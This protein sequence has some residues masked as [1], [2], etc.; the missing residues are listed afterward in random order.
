[1]GV[2]RKRVV[3]RVK[4]LPT[5][6]VGGG[7]ELLPSNKEGF[8]FRL[9]LRVNECK[10]AVPG[11]SYRIA[12][13]EISFGLD[14]QNCV[15]P[16]EDWELDPPIELQIETEEVL[17]VSNAVLDGDDNGSNA[18]AGLSI[19]TL[20]KPV[21]LSASLAVDQKITHSESRRVSQKTTQKSVSRMI[22]SAGNELEPKWFLKAKNSAEHLAGAIWKS[23]H[24]LRLVPTD[25]NSNVAL[26]VSLPSHGVLVGNDAGGFEKLG[27]RNILARWLIKRA[28]CN[29]EIVLHQKSIDGDE[30]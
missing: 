11:G 3:R 25:S 7:F 21:E 6:L 10:L 19:G 18:N 23:N 28:I 14:L 26:W 8:S 16:S 12:L 17:E 1:M 9:S 27:N 2:N 5:S 24:F 4:K 20:P 29:E 30:T 13:T 15:A 22:S